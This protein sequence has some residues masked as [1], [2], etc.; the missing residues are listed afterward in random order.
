MLTKKLHFIDI[1]KIYLGHNHPLFLK[2]GEINLK[3]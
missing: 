3:Q 2:E 1:L